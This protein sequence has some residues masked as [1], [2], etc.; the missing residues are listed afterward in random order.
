MGFGGLDITSK[1]II[2]IKSK[3][4]SNWKSL[5]LTGIGVDKKTFVAK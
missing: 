4:P 5:T 2:Q 3:L 1:G